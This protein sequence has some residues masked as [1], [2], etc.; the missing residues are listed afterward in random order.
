ML[1][2]V[3]LAAQTRIE[4]VSVTYQGRE[5]EG[6]SDSPS[7]S[8]DGRFVAF[9]SNA[10][11]TGGQDGLP[12]LDVFVRDR[13]RQPGDPGAIERISV[14]GD[15]GEP[16]DDSSEPSISADGRIVAFSSRASNLVQNDGNGVEDVFVRNRETGVTK[17]ISVSSVGGD[18]NGQSSFPD[19]SADGRYVVFQSQASNLVTGDDN[20]TSDIFRYDR[21]TGETLRVSIN[22]SG[23]GGN[24]ASITPSISADGQ[25]VAFISSATNLVD[26]DTNEVPDVFVRSLGSD[27]TERVS[28]S[29]LEEQANRISFLPSVNEDGSLVAFKSEASN[30]VPG[31]T[32]GVLDVFIRDRSAETTTR[33]SVDDSG[34]Q[35]NG[36]SG[37]PSISGDGCDVAFAS[38]ATNLVLQDDNGNT[39]L[40]VVDRCGRNGE[41]KIVRVGASLGPQS[42]NGSVPEVPPSVS[43]NGQWVAF[44]SSATDLVP[45]EPDLN[46]ELDAFITGNPLNPPPSEPTH[47]PTPTPTP[48]NDAQCPPGQVCDPDTNLCVDTTRTPTRTPTVTPTPCN[49]A[50][51][52]PGQVCDPNTNLCVDATPTPTP[53]FQCTTNED[54]P[55]GQVCDPETHMC[56]TPTP[57]GD[58][59]GG[60]GCNCEIS[61]TQRHESPLE[62]LALVLPAV[63]LWLRR[64]A[65]RPV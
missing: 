11:L 64:R 47:T 16:N 7:A 49:D 48:C 45:G 24:G 61:P 35:S 56:V 29:G 15:G 36:L 18:A 52:P 22:S 20:G 32:N 5:A 60:G 58:G 62:A 19:V 63:L 13:E 17:R 37:P 50:Q 1:V 27:D 44:A 21:E 54:C 28:V 30:L 51:C 9:V 26:G 6:R 25:V 41:R 33:I 31:D 14:A 59:G 39:D 53:T 4:R 10:N 43:L 8:H 34:I 46:N 23:A 40:F 65:R 2:P 38:A 42:P 55:P 57:S 3:S 12:E